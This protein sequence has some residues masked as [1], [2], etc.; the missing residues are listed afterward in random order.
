MKNKLFFFGNYQGT[1]LVEASATNTTYTPTP[2]MLKGDFS[3]LAPQR[4]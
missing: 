1:R 4:E 3:G 2:A